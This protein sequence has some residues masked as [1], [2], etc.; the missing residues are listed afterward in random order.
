M[1]LPV[2]GI[3]L[4]CL[5]GA[6]QRSGLCQPHGPERSRRPIV[7]LPQQRASLASNK[8]SRKVT[9]RRRSNETKCRT[10]PSCSLVLPNEE[11]VF[12]FLNVATFPFWGAML[13]APKQDLTKKVMSSYSLFIAL[14]GIYLYLAYISLSEPAILEGF[15]NS[16]DL[17]ALT[18]AFSYEKTVAVGWAHFIAED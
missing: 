5:S 8:V 4:T 17:A 18:N 15:S 13:V 14:G 2:R 1:A 10:V 6:V 3:C 12:N 11:A 7:S 9:L 16:Q